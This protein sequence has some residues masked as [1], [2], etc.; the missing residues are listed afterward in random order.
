MF[1]SSFLQTLRDY[2]GGGTD[3]LYSVGS[4]VRAIS[5]TKAS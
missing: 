4:E 2:S 3:A 5:L 1:Y